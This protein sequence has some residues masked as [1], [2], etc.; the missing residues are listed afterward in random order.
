MVGKV[1][2]ERDDMSEHLQGE[3]KVESEAKGKDG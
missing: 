3:G 2:K 1:M